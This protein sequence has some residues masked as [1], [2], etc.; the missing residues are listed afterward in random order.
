MISAR[1]NQDFLP[2]FL[3]DFDKIYQDYLDM[4]HFY[5]AIILVK[6]CHNSGQILP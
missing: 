4:Q 2:G 5:L 3:Q 6:S 1:F